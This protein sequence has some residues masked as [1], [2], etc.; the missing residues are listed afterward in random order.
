MDANAYIDRAAETLLRADL[1]RIERPS[2]RRMASG[3]AAI[4]DFY[5]T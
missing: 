1:L 3:L 2:S 4:C 5:E